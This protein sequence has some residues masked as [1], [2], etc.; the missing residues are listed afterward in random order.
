MI[1]LS[2]ILF[3]VPEVMVTDRKSA[4][5]PRSRGT[6]ETRELSP[7]CVCVRNTINVYR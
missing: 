3:G 1:Y 4:R 7:V 2:D 6:N 5:R